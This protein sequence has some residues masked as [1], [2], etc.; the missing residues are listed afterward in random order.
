MKINVF[1][2]NRICAYK[3]E[4][5]CSTGRTPAHENNRF[6][7]DL[8]DGGEVQVCVQRMTTDEISDAGFNQNFILKKSIWSKSAINI[9]D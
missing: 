3:E 6:A 7:V 4:S 9:G 2:D 5:V 1:N 8:K